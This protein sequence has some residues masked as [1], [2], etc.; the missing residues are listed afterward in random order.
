MRRMFLRHTMFRRLSYISIIWM[1]EVDVDINVLRM[2]A[3]SLSVV[4]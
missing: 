2:I 3:G 4:E 1:T